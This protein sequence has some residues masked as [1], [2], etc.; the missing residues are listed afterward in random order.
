MTVALIT[1]AGVGSRFGTD[2]PKQFLTVYNKPIIIYT[3]E[4]FQN[5]PS[6]DEIIVICL[7][8]W[9]PI[10]SAYAKQF[11]ITKLKTIVS[12]G[13]SGQES[14]K[15]GILALK[16]THDDDTIV[17]VHDGNRALVSEEIISDSVVTCKECGNA[18][19]VIPCQEVIVETS[20]QKTSQTYLVRENLK[21]TQTPHAFFL[22]DMI[23][24]HEQAEQ[25]SIY[26]AAATCDLMMR[27]GKTI[28]FS[29]GNE[30]NIKITTEDDM[31]IFKALVIHN[32]K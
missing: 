26:D 29:K 4:K 16:D 32:E 18:V 2:V 21:R 3:L 9:Q 8:G 22:K 28:Y 23:W 24:A 17:L 1:A 5:H 15:K 20:D 10:L 30:T 25:K 19:S 6:I 12:G 27:L 13:K 7:D 11:G 31:K 14:I